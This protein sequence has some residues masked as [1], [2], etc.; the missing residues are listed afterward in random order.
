MNLDQKDREILRILQQDAR[1][2]NHDLARKVSLSASPCLR[3]VKRLHDSGIIRSQ[4]TLLDANMLGYPLLAYAH[5]SLDDHHTDTVQAFDQFV[6]DCPEVLECCATSGEH[7][8]LLKVRSASMQ[9]YEDFLRKGLMQ[10]VG[11]RTVNTSFVMSQ[12]KN[13][14]ALPL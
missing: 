6:M 4:V 10:I 2:S 7:D 13:S 14:T 9:D 12:K 1:I 11:I 5:V 8:Y 3:R